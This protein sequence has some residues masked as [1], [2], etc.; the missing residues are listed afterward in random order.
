MQSLP[1]LEFT[2]NS[3]QVNNY[4]LNNGGTCSMM[5]SAQIPNGVYRSGSNPNGLNGESLPPSP[6][7]QQSCFNSP[8]GSPGPLSISP[9][10]LNPF[11][12]TNPNAQLQT[13]NYNYDL[14]QKKFDMINLETSSQYNNYISGFNPYTQAPTSPNILPNSS[15]KMNVQSLSMNGGNIINNCIKTSNMNKPIE[16]NNSNKSY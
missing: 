15:N 10:D 2:I 1:S 12:T 8:Q 4:L 6:Q 9:Q 13:S 7:S 16:N 14:M 3:Q 11:S 5:N